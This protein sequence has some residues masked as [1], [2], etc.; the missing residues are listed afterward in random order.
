MLVAAHVGRR[1]L[2]GSDA[3][4]IS[5][6]IRPRCMLLLF[7]SIDNTPGIQHDVETVCTECDLL[8]VGL[9]AF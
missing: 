9:D 6:P 8:S 3:A 1:W 2:S 5:L 7:V 4:Y